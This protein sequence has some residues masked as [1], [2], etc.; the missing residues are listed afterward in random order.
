MCGCICRETGAL[1]FKIHE[2]KKREKWLK[3]NVRAGRFRPDVKKMYIYLYIQFKQRIKMMFLPS[4]ISI[5]GSLKSVF[6]AGHSHK[7]TA[8]LDFIW[9]VMK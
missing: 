1:C 7:A 5:L 6:P 3:S 4:V 9:T 2:K 8:G